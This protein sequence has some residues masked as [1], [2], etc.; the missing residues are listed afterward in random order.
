MIDLK[1]RVVVPARFFE[2]QVS[3]QVGVDSL[4]T[5]R[6]MRSITAAWITA[7]EQLDVGF[8]VACETAVVHRP[9]EGLLGHPSSGDHLEPLFAGPALDDFDVDS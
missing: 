2:F 3:R 9:V 8:V 4:M 5:H 7:S 6:L 1:G